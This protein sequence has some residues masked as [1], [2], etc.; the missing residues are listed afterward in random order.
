MRRVIL[1]TFSLLVA[2]G[3]LAACGSDDSDDADMGSSDT[4]TADDTMDETDGMDDMTSMDG[5]EDHGESSDVAEGAREIE[6]NASSFAFDP[7]EIEVQAGE[8]VAIALTST[9]ILHDLTIDELDTHVAADA[10]ETATG[11]LRAD[12]PGRYTFYCTVAGHREAGMEG[13]LVVEE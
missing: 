12:E 11:G 4:S 2:T 1:I 9:D 7:A 10:G 8:D 5:T 13:T 3:L 6:V